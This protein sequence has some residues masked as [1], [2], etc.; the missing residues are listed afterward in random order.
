MNFS[1]RSYFQLSNDVRFID[2]ER[3]S[4]EKVQFSAFYT[5]VLYQDLGLDLENK[6]SQ[7]VVQIGPVSGGILSAMNDAYYCFITK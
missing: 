6:P 5:L 3:I 1:R 4:L 2:L 7:N